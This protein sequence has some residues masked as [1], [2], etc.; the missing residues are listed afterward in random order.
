MGGCQSPLWHLKVPL[1]YFIKCKTNIKQLSINVYTFEVKGGYFLVKNWCYPILWTSIHSYNLCYLHGHKTTGKP[2]TTNIYT[3]YNAQL[4]ICNFRFHPTWHCPW[5]YGS[6]CYYIT[7]IDYPF[8]WCKVSYFSAIWNSNMKS[9]ILNYRDV[10][11]YL[12]S[13]IA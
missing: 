7:F 8:Q 3:K 2:S 6:M 10:Y 1:V 5:T 9:E 12:F 4:C 11:F 13:Y